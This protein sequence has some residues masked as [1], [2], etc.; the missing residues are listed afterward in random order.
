MLFTDPVII[1]NIIKSFR[2]KNIQQDIHRIA[3][4]RIIILQGA[5]KAC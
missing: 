3:R 5:T 2:E 4:K 1:Q